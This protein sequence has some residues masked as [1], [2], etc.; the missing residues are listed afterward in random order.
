MTHDEQEALIAA[1]WPPLLIVELKRRG[2]RES[3]PD[4]ARLIVGDDRTWFLRQTT[5]PH[6]HIGIHKGDDLEAL[7]TAIHDAALRIGHAT[8][9]GRFMHFLDHCKAWRPDPAA[10]LTALEARLAKLETALERSTSN[11]ERS[12]FNVGS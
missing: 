12:T 2:F 1:G 7:D 4:S 10:D 9:A 3:G 8:L 11:I 5:L 6:I